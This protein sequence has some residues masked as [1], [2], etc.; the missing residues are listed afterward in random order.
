MKHGKRFNVASENENKTLLQS[1]AFV[2][3]KCRWC[4]IRITQKSGE[5]NSVGL[6]HCWCV[7][8]EERV[9]AQTMMV[10]TLLNIS[11]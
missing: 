6:S 7:C 9:S 2:Q 1:C 11:G 10:R 3:L 4:V 5:E 8:V